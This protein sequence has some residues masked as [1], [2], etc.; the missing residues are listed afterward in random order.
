MLVQVN[1][2]RAQIESYIDHYEASGYSLIKKTIDSEEAV[3]VFRGISTSHAAEAAAWDG[4][5]QAFIEFA[6]GSK[7][8]LFIRNRR[9]LDD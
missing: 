3:L 9:W 1:C 7:S 4:N 6:D 2:H 5:A 8:P